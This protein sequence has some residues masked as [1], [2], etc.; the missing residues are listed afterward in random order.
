MATRSVTGTLYH[1]DGA[2]VWANAP[3][4]ITPKFAGAY[5][6]A[7]VTDASGV[8][9]ITVPLPDSGNG[10]YVA[11][12]PGD[13]IFS[14]IMG[15]G[16]TAYDISTLMASVESVAPVSQAQTLVDGANVAWN[17]AL[18]A[19][20]V[21]TLAGSRTMLAPSNLVAGMV[22]H[23]KLIQDSTGSRVITWNTVF[24]WAGG[25]APTLS[26]GAGKIDYI[27]FV[28]DGTNLI[29]TAILDAR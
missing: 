3:V 17:M 28:S 26:T 23:L 25:T 29:G 20:G 12:F 11:R 15:Q 13:V 19:F 2:T 1:A 5:E 24:K 18:G 10:T 7:G 6:S 22:Y 8:F 9:T 21:L 27:R 14:F 4:I 16:A